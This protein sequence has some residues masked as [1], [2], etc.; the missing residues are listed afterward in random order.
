MAVIIGNL[1]IIR[2]DE[3][4]TSWPQNG[5]DGEQ[6]QKRKIQ[7]TLYCEEQREGER[8]NMWEKIKSKEARKML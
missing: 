5:S 1:P 7:R 6:K 3:L 8:E 4:L 2:N